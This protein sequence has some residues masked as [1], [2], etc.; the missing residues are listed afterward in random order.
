MRGAIVGDIIGSVHESRCGKTKEFPLFVPHTTFTD[1]TVLTVAVAD[2]LLTG[3]S[4][5]DKFHEYTRAYPNRGYGAGFWHWVRSG[6]REPYNS[7]GNGAAMRVSPVGFAFGSLTEVLDE[8]KRSAEVTHNHPEGIRGAQAT[9]AAVF[10]ARTGKSKEEIREFVE[11]SF[12]YDLDRTLDDIR[13]SYSFNESCQGTVPEAI[14]AF[15]D[16]SDYEDAVRL[17]I[18]L[19]GDADTL[20][21]ITGGIAGAFYGGVPEAIA[22]PAMALLHPELRHVV[23]RFCE[24][25][26]TT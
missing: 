8:A 3:S 17:A 21:C 11:A 26:G 18:S 12:G 6:S 20:A 4:Y 15:L 25:Y 19:G 9:A 23:D 24:K 5:V 7:W 16:S 2:C 13:P 22:A 10:L 14:T 1:D